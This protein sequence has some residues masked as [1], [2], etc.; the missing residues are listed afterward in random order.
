MKEEATSL[1]CLL[2]FPA[3]TILHQRRRYSVP[4]ARRELSLS[5]LSS[6]H[7]F[8][9]AQH[10]YKASCGLHPPYLQSLFTLTSATHGH[11]TRQAFTVSVHLLL[12]RTNFREKA[13]SY[14]GAAIWNSLPTNTSIAPTISAFNFII[15]P[16]LLST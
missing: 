2:N 9:L 3:Q 11:W 16:Y 15:H 6:R 14:R 5:T 10:S 7:D 12:P 8:N 1:E 4:S 13:F